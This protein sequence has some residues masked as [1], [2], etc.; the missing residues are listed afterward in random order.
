MDYN[1]YSLNRDNSKKEIVGQMHSAP[2]DKSSHAFAMFFCAWV[3]TYEKRHAREYG[4][5]AEQVVKRTAE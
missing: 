1:I 3:T 4:Y 2:E 5:E